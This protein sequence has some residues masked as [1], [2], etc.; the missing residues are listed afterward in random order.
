MIRIKKGLDLPIAGK[1]EALVEDARA[2]RTVAVLGEDFPGMKPTML[3]QEGDEVSLGQPLFSDKKND[4]V[5]FT[6]PAKGRIRVMVA[7]CVQR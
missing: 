3:V 4:G 7:S 5:V 2:V 1:P 6:A